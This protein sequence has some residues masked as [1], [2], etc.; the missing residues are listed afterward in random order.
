MQKMKKSKRRGIKIF[1]SGS[2]F[3]KGLLT[4]ILALDYLLLGVASGIV[5]SAFFLKMH[6]N[7]G[8]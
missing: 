7:K 5:I 4:V 6:K 8:G 1:I 3:I 2:K